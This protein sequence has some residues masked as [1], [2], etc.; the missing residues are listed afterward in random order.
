MAKRFVVEDHP[1]LLGKI[2]GN[3]ISIE[4]SA[5]LVLENQ[6]PG[7]LKALMNQLAHFKE[8]DWV[9]VSPISDPDGL[10]GV[11]NQYN[12]SVEAAHPGLKLDTERIVF[13]RD[14]LAHGRIFGVMDPKAG[15]YLR[16]LKFDKNKANGKVQVLL[17]IEMTREWFD[18]TAALLSAA[19][20]KIRKALDWESAELGS[21]SKPKPESSMPPTS[22]G[23][24]K[25][26]V[27]F[28]KL[29]AENWLK[30]DPVFLKTAAISVRDAFT[31]ALTQNGK[32]IDLPEVVVPAEG[33][34]E[35][36]H[37]AQLHTGVPKDIRSLFE[38]ARA[39]FVYGYC[40]YPLCTL[41]T[42]QMFRVVEAAISAR[43]LGVAGAPKKKAPFEQ[44]IEWLIQKGQLTKQKG[45][46]LHAIRTLR[47]ETSH[48]KHQM[49]VPPQVAGF[50]LMDLSTT[51]NELFPRPEDKAATA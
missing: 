31:L 7:N 15:P 39:M 11:L 6:K 30:P 51:I 9:D 35:S 41:A 5:R 44:K 48:P 13:L 46:G 3:L 50:M 19:I 20:E 17:R 4:L 38:A 45:T 26:D 25:D 8:G 21:Y 16:L 18:E 34:L 14:A 37:K 29:T 24:N 33:W 28:K 43:C 1:L 23:T 27:G 49:L 12:A 22:Q 2:I 47:N 32:D 36:I 10:R 40:F 42:E